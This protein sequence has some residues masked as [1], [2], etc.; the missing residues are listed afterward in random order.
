MYAKTSSAKTPRVSPGTPCDT[1]NATGR[2]LRRR[3][4]AEF[5]A[6]DLPWVAYG[7]FSM[8]RVVPGYAGP[9]SS[10]ET[11]VAN[12]ALRPLTAVVRSARMAAVSAILN[13]AWS[14]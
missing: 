13:S 3:L 11:Q 12:D 4:N 1:A 14:D 6:R 9:R 10:S 5:A 7:E 2:L 8:F